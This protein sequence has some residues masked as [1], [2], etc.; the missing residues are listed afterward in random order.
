MAKS[1][2]NAA[3][4]GKLGKDLPSTEERPAEIAQQT[5]QKMINQ[6]NSA[7]LTPEELRR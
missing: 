4:D 5:L 1:S 6:L 2:T 3:T 7:K